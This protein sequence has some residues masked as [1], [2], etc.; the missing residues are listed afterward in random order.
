[1]DVLKSDKGLIEE[2]SNIEFLRLLTCS[3][4]GH[5]V[6]HL[7]HVGVLV[8]EL[9]GARQDGHRAVPQVTRVVHLKREY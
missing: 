9:V 3:A 1:M 6:Q 7:L 2:K 5:I 8:P 4:A